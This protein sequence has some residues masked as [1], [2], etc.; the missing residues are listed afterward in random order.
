MRD[1]KQRLLVLWLLA[2]TLAC[3]DLWLNVLLPSPDW[4]LHHRSAL[5]AIGCTLVLAA[6]VPL[7]RVRSSAVTVGAGIF[8]GGVL[9]NLISGASD[10]LVVPNPLLLQMGSGGIAFN[11]A[12][13]FIL[14]GNLILMVS[15]CAFVVRRRRQPHAVADAIRVPHGSD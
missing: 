6:V 8:A 9:G 10:H 2:T 11:L 3:F 15:L 5:W 7:T 1:R 14:A 13:T 4:A 12:D